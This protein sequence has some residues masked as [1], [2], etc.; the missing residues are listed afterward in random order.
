MLVF[1]GLVFAGL[2]GW[3]LYNLYKN[4]KDVADN[5]N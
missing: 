5:Q 1:A 4:G 3:W 2:G